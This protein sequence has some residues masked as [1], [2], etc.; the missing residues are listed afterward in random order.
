MHIHYSEPITPEIALH[1]EYM[2]ANILFRR[3]NISC[4][5][6]ACKIVCKKFAPVEPKTQKLLI[7]IAVWVDIIDHKIHCFPKGPYW[8]PLS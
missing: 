5:C 3:C 1:T 7:N 6:V 8:I 2:F 4:C